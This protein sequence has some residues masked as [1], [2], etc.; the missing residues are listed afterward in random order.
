MKP[1]WMRHPVTGVDGAAGDPAR[2]AA[3]ARHL[4]EYESA[5]EREP[6]AEFRARLSLATAQAVRFQGTRGWML[7]TRRYG[8]AAFR[9]SIAAAAAAA[10]LLS[11]MPS[12]EQNGERDVVLAAAVGAASTRDL[13]SAWT[14]GTG[15]ERDFLG[16]F[17]VVTP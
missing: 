8:R 1:F 7:A 10:I 13:A 3:L 15:A 16:A 2:D 4:E 11:R 6:S 5:A 9:I 17:G 14:A 12:P